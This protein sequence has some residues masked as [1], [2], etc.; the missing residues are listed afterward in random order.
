MSKVLLS[1]E[2]VIVLLTHS[3][4]F[5]NMK[6]LYVYLLVFFALLTVNVTAQQTSK[7]LRFAFLT[8]IHLNAPNDNDRY[9]GLKTALAKVKDYQ[10]DFIL[11]GGDH[12]DVS[13]MGNDHSFEKAD[14]MYRMIKQTFE[15]TKIPFYPTLG[16]HDRYFNPDMGYT[17]GDELFKSH[18]NQ[19]YYTFE[20][21]GIRFFVLNS[22]QKKAEPGYYIGEEQM[23]W[24]KKELAGIS[25]ETPVIVSTHVP[26][27]SIYY[28]VVEG[29]YVF[30]D[31]IANYKE[32]LKT[33]E[34]HNLK[35][36]LQGH[37]H[38][39]EEIFSQ[40]IQYITGGAVSAN[41]WQGAFYGTEE[42]FLLLEIDNN[43]NIDWEYI[44]YGWEPKP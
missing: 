25:K 34:E 27:Y 41:W 9:N 29:K 1:F 20:K 24:L 19:S 30:V 44:D 28:P 43:D 17:A 37:Q 18:F 13:G 31:V 4:K 21:N 26:V 14:S 22:V 6:N 16:N 10:V 35:M 8:D 5:C 23:K 2:V 36:V 33:F 32:L 12:V 3:L 40:K 42:G 7:K 39:Y 38:L 15:E 11:T